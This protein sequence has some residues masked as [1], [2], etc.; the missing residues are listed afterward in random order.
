MP[1][2]FVPIEA[3]RIR[4]SVHRRRRPGQRAGSENAV[5]DDPVAEFLTREVVALPTART[6]NAHSA[7]SAR[8]VRLYRAEV[9]HL[10]DGLVA[11]AGI[12]SPGAREPD[13]VL[14]SPGVDTDFGAPLR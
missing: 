13:S 11:A 7:E 6:P 1:R 8:A 3:T 9:E 10:D 14:W 2:G 5:T 12:R 4:T